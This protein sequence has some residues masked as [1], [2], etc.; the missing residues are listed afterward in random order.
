MKVPSILPA[1]VVIKGLAAIIVV[2]EVYVLEVGVT[3]A[4]TSV[5][6]KNT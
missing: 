3:Y 5:P 1:A 4:F 6:S 2:S